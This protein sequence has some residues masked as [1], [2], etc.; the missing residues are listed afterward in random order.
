MPRSLI[1]FLLALTMTL[2]I[3]SGAHAYVWSRLVVAPRWDD[4]S[5]VRGATAAIAA[6]AVLA[7]AGMIIGRV[8]RRPWARLVALAS[9][10]WLGVLIM[11]WFGLLVAEPVRALMSRWVAEPMGSR[12]IAS[13]L[14]ALVAVGAV[15]G[16]ISAR[17]EVGVRRVQVS[18]RKL[19]HARAGYRLVQISDL[20]IGPTLKRDWLARIVAQVNELEPDAVAITGDLVDGSVKSLREHVAP[21]ADLRAKDGVFFVTGNHEYYSGVDAWLAELRRLGVKPLRNERVSVGG[22][23]GFDIAGVDDYNAFGKGHGRDLARALAGRDES[24]ELVLLAHQPRQVREAA[25]HGVG[26]Q[27]SGHTH[28]GQIFPWNLFVR[29][30][31][32]FVAGMHRVKETQLYVSRGTGY[33]GPPMRVLAPA[34]ITLLELSP[35]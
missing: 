22:E 13:G 4:P 14:C 2:A 10:S 8:S 17:G 33:W 23:Q 12:G 35:G 31:Q 24:R 26:L 34:E 6:L 15:S 21:L 29:L 7:P 30:Q 18:L 16:V 1:T 28:G 19:P 3:V 32:P 11:L 5:L 9:Y 27:I 20:H 25:E